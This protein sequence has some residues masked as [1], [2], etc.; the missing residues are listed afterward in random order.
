MRK[1]FAIDELRAQTSWDWRIALDFFLVGTG[2]ALFLISGAL[3]LFAGLATGIALVAVGSA[4]VLSHLGRPQSMWR[5]ASQFRTSWMSR[6]IIAAGLFVV[7]GMLAAAPYVFEGLPWSQG[8]WTRGDFLGLAIW[9][10]AAVAGV[11]FI[12]YPGMVMSTNRSIPFWHTRMLPLVVVSYGVVGALAVVFIV[13]SVVD[14]SLS[15]TALGYYGLTSL[16]ASALLTYLHISSK[17]SSRDLASKESVRLILRGSLAS[18]FMLGAILVGVVAP[19]ILIVVAFVTSGS[20]ATSSLFLAGVLMLV[21]AFLARYCLVK[22][23]GY[24]TLL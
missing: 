5:S 6:G 2:T 22:A 20:I 21:G 10:V 1:E 4:V 23:G 19:V 13:Q 14:I 8:S 3:H 7:F 11:V 17:A 18:V 15:E 9:Y 16:V 24:A 12:L